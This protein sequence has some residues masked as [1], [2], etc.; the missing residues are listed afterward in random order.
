MTRT[1]HA[2]LMFAMLAALSASAAVYRFEVD[3]FGLGDEIWGEYPFGMDS[4]RMVPP[5]P[6]AP[7]GYEITYPEP[8]GTDSLTWRHRRS[9]LAVRTCL[10]CPDRVLS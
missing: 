2:I 4:S 6:D 7:P 9:G 1:I 3:G 8:P 10:S 5:D